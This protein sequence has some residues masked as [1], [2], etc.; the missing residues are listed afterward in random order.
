MSAMLVTTTYAQQSKNK[1]R[2]TPPSVEELM[3]MDANKDGKLS[4]AEV[5]GPLAKKFP[6]MDLNS[7]GFLTKDE[8]E[9][10]PQKPARNKKN[11]AEEQGKKERGKQGEDPLSK[12]DTNKDGKLS[13][14]EVKGPLSDDLSLIH[15]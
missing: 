5:K 3:K 13:K 7:D 4:K 8:L 6:K 11:T 15:I 9:K 10:A 14:A 12:M 1:K 2:D